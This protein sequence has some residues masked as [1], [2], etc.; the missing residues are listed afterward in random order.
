MTTP[1]ETPLTAESI[2]R[3]GVV[4]IEIKQKANHDHGI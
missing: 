4:G 2:T 3:Y 1:T